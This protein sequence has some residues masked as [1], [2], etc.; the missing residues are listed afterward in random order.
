MTS[1]LVFRSKPIPRVRK[2]DH[3]RHGGPKKGTPK[4]GYE[5]ADLANRVARR[6]QLTMGVKFTSYLCWCRMWHVGRGKA[7]WGHTATWDARSELDVCELGVRVTANLH[8]ENAAPQ[9]H[10]A[11]LQRTLSRLEK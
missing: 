10:V 1:H 6:Q 4:H 5:N 8:R 9:H 11:A 3:Y 7:R 2:T